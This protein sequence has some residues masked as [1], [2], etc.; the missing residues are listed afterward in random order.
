MIKFKKK[1]QWLWDLHVVSMKP[2]EYFHYME[3]KYGQRWYDFVDRRFEEK[4]GI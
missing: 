4:F 2:G 1:L 3:K